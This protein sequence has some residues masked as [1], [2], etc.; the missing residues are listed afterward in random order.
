MDDEISGAMKV[1]M[2]YRHA[3][4]LCFG[5][6]IGDHQPYEGMLDDRFYRAFPGRW[7][8]SPACW[9]R[10][11]R[12]HTVQANDDAW[13]ARV[14][15]P[16]PIHAA[17]LPS[18]GRAARLRRQVLACLGLS[19]FPYTKDQPGDLL[20]LDVR[21]GGKRDY[22]DF[23]VQALAWQTWQGVYA[24]GYLYLPKADRRPIRPSCTRTA[25]SRWARPRPRC[26]AAASPSPS[27]A[28]SACRSRAPIP[29]ACPGA[30]P[31]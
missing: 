14:T 30:F 4:R 7:R 13:L 26:N 28:T 12:E 23:S 5:N 18:G 9:T 27:R 31:P 16:Q 17:D 10:P 3:A 1:E 21:W 29:R 22:P 24:H 25:T 19:P 20:P 15:A 8:G 2:H 6:N 11:R